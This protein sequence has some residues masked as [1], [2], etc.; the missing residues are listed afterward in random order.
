MG[1]RS[2]TVI[3]QD[4][5]LLMVRQMYKGEQF[6]TFPGGSVEIGETP[7]QAAIREVFEETGLTV[8]KVE[9]L[10]ETYS[11]KI[12]GMY[13]C[14]FGMKWEG[15]VKLGHDPELHNRE[16]ELKEVRWIPIEELQENEEVNRVLPLI[17]EQLNK[18]QLQI[19]GEISAILAA[20]HVRF[21]LRGGWA[22]DFLL[23]R[24]TRK[25]ADIDLVAW[26][27][28]QGRIEKALMEAGFERTPISS[29]QTD[30]CKDG[31]D[32]QFCY[33]TRTEE[34]AIHPEG[35]SQWIWRPDAL[36]LRL[37]IFQG[38]SARTMNPRQLLQEKED[39]K[40]IGRPT[41]AKDLQSAKL[42]KEIIAQTNLIY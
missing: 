28:H 31:V 21:W 7:D 1:T 13:Y 30:F 17:F 20:L 3:I 5:Q 22:I 33:L 10:F 41:R 24:I 39:Y 35:K 23:G 15:Q 29:S 27:R 38:L 11:E 16:Q 26:V 32:L 34:G 37:R 12:Q 25:H 2:C 14:F 8:D 36:P 19:L 4:N 9:P 6:W 40:R 18:G 42:L